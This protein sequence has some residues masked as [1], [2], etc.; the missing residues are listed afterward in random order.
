MEKLFHEDNII[1]IIL[2]HLFNLMLLNLLTLICCIPIITIG[3]SLTAM[4]HV[5]IT[6]IEGK[7]GEV[8]KPFFRSFRKNFMPATIIFMGILGVFSVMVSIVI[9]LSDK[10]DTVFLV[11]SILAVLVTILCLMIFCYVFPLLATFENTIRQTVYNA[12]A[13][14][15]THIPQSFAMLSILIVYGKLMSSYWQ[16]ILAFFFLFGISIPGWLFMKLYVPILNSI[17]GTEEE[18][19]NTEEE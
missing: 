17:L 5:L 9:V 15:L 7:G 10:K 18:Y 2:G 3:A 6:E 13:L 8:I 16:N 4:H 19:T 12:G 14:A 1:I 11:I